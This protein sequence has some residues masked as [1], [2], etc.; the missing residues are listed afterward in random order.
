M[1]ISEPRFGSRKKSHRLD[2]TYTI[3]EGP[4]VILDSVMTLGAKVTKQSLIDRTVQ[5]KTET[6]L[7]EDD[8]LAAEGR[9]YVLESSIGPR[10][11]RAAR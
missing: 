9:L 6:P 3:S 7:R 2:I 10:L 4:K 5:L 11:T 8:L 1:Q